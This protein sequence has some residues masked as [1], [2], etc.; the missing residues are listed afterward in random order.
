MLPFIS[1]L[2]RER[3][4]CCMPYKHRF[5]PHVTV[6]Y[7]VKMMGAHRGSDEMQGRLVR[8][9]TQLL[10]EESESVLRPTLAL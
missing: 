7:R 8:I 10:V 6:F 4:L 5:S 2:P 3:L 9:K 1:L